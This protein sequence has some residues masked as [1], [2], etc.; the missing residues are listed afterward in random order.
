MNNHDILIYHKFLF[1]ICISSF[2]YKIK[3][4]LLELYIII[5]FKFIIKVGFY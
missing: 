1:Y 5:H 4:T 3:L 2:I